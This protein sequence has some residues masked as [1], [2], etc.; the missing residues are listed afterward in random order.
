MP[1]RTQNLGLNQWAATDY[2]RREDFNEDN[3]K[4]DAVMGS[5]HHFPLAEFT[6]TAAQSRL[7]IDVS[8]VDWSAY[9]SVCVELA[10]RVSATGRVCV[11]AN[12]PDAYNSGHYAELFA[13][14]VTELGL[15]DL[16]GFSTNIDARLTLYPYKRAGY[17]LNSF[18]ERAATFPCWGRH[19]TLT[20]AELTKLYIVPETA[21]V[22]ILSGASVKVWG[23]K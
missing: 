21:G 12:T 18:C 9:R 11:R 16:S 15:A 3:A 13:N 2:V 1:D 22:T 4:I 19:P 5:L 6:T 23:E 17:T 20:F 14:L 7:E 10:F 8:S